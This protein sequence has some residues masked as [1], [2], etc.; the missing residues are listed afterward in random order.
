MVA[1]GGHSVPKKKIR[2]RHRR[3]W[4]LVAVAMARADQATVYDNSSNQGP[5]SVA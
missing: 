2:W 5:R 4:R 1:A 3:L